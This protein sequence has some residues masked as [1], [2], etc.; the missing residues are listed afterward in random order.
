MSPERTKS[1]LTVNFPPTDTSLPTVKAVP[2]SARPSV[3]N[4][5]AY[6][7]FAVFTLP[8]T[9]LPVTLS[10]PLIPASFVILKL[11]ATTEAEAVRCATL[12][13]PDILALVEL[14]VVAVVSPKVAF[15]VIL[16]LSATKEP[17]AIKC[18]AV[19]FDVTLELSETTEP[20]AVT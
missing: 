10:V 2:I 11:S 19:E 8:K 7:I 6:I 4:E 14:I 16:A 3:L 15:A 17:V 12:A 18:A 9:E 5:P 13:L 1:P 20:V